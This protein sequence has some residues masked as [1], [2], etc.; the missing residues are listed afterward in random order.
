VPL[1]GANRLAQFAALLK[2]MKPWS[3][4]VPKGF[5][6]DF[7]GVL[8]D[9][10]FTPDHRGPFKDGDVTTSLPSADGGE[11]WFEMVD[12]VVSAREATG[13][14]VAVSLGASYGAQLVGAW[15]ALKAVN[16]LPARLVA[17]EAVPENCAWIR[18]HMTNNGIDPDDHTIIQ[19]AIGPDNEPA[20]F[21]TGAP[22]SGRNNCVATNSAEARQTY[23]HLLR[24]QGY[25]ERV[26]ENLLI[27][28]TT[29]ITRDLGGGYGGEVKFVS[30][31]TLADVLS[32]FER[33]DLLEVDIQQSEINVIPPFMDLLDR[34]VRRA[35]IG[36]HGRDVHQ[37]LRLL[38]FKAGWEV[39]FD[40]APDSGFETEFGSFDTSDC[41]LTVRNPRV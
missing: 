27:Y 6:A 8:T 14:Y 3:G 12:W 10:T 2:S 21:P 5:F 9:T 7:L 34:K 40:Y 22:G 13:A 4:H 30:S 15:K 35:H 28:N 39:V 19:A 17:V 11:G 23:A 33:I 38:F 24:Q 1:P 26:L 25:S 37:S 20:L 16:D 32:P 36:T 29:G 41:V 18:Q 31:V